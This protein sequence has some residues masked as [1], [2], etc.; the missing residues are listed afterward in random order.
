[1]KT[2][3]TVFSIILLS[4]VYFSQISAQSPDNT[5]LTHL[6]WR[7]I[8]PHRGGRT[9]GVAGIPDRPNVFYIGV[10]NGGGGGPSDYG[11]TWK[12]IFD[13]QPTG[14]I[15]AIAVA[16]SNPDILYV[17]SGEGL[18]RPDL[19]VG[20]GIFKSTDEGKT[21]KHMGLADALQ[22]GAVIVDPRNP[23]RVFVAA[24]GHTYGANTERGVF[25]TTDGGVSWGKGLYKD[26]NTGAIALEFEPTNPQIVFAS[27]WSARQGPWENGAGEGKTRGLFKSTDGGNT[28]R[29]LT[30][31]LPTADQGV[32]RIGI[33]IA[34][35]DPSRMYA[36][37]DA[38]EKGGIH[39]S[40]DAGEHWVHVTS[41][42]R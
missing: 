31:G 37:V 26:E 10:N 39:R 30:G 23:D 35:N 22:I 29:Q 11:R 19:S 24:L 38:R 40:D 2:P 36:V 5:P 1:M 25:R 20:D 42:G 12:P 17:G 41:E 7:M 6:H 33:A 14:S 15:G 32:G 4:C 9:V 27:L 21:W 34:P 13:D 28:W 16:P 8:G 3:S 18:Q